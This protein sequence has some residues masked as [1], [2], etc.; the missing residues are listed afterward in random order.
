VVWASIGGHQ[1]VAV[2]RAGRVDAPGRRRV[3]LYY[4]KDASRG[5]A[6]I[7]PL[8]DGPGGLP[9]GDVSL[10]AGLLRLGRSTRRRLL[11]DGVLPVNRMNDMVRRVSWPP[12]RSRWFVL[13]D[14]SGAVLMQHRDEHAPVA[15]NVW[16][17]PGGHIE[18]AKPRNRPPGGNCS[19][20]RPGCRRAERVVERSHAQPS[21]AFP[22]RSRC[23]SS[24]GTTEAKQQD[25]VLGEGRAMV[26]VPAL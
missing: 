23:T 15:P 6:V 18:P 17:P 11:R 26:F 7:F 4:A 10:G 25:V 24:M 12:T 9:I 1:G 16:T 22:T 3:K 8:L 21:R 19:R 5:D 13:T 2:V 20:S 14:A